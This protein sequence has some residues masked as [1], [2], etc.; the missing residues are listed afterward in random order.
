MWQAA[1]D[2]EMASLVEKNTW[3]QDDSPSAQPLPTHVILKIKRDADGN[4]DRFKARV[5]A[6]GNF[7]TYGKD[8]METYAPVAPFCL[9]RLFLYLTLC[10]QMSIAQVD[11]KTA[12]LNGDLKEDVWVMSPRGV[13]GII[14][15][16]FKLLKAM[17]GLK[18][19]HLAWHT[20]L[21][22]DLNGIG[23]F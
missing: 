19:A 1:I 21:C 9:V 23:F 2:A 5:V 13:P 7:Q 8:Y 6:G 14:S 4:V 10:L 18:Q 16:C 3:I 22:A 15:T 17:Y 12:F 11:I 20:K